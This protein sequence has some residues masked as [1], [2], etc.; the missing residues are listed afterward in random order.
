[1]REWRTRLASF[2]LAE[3]VD[4]V[5]GAPF[6]IWIDGQGPPADS[7]SPLPVASRRNRENPAPLPANL[8]RSAGCGPPA[9]SVKG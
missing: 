2:C 7:D 4:I 6:R 3:S 5:C 9:A 1:M 8:I